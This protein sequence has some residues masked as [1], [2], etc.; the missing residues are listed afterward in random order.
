MK[1]I[2]LVMAAALLVCRAGLGADGVPAPAD[3]VAY[4]ARVLMDYGALGLFV[5]FLLLDRK[6]ERERRD[7][8]AE[9]WYA[10]D[11]RLIDRMESGTVAM[12]D[13]ATALK[14]LREI[15]KENDKAMQRVSTM[16][17]TGSP[18]GR[19]ATDNDLE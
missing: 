3:P 2:F 1:T 7:R 16:L 11:Q 8:D 13:T 17:A 12:Q 9:R 18:R 4:A 15:I 6:K 10:M 14:E 5:A 19:R